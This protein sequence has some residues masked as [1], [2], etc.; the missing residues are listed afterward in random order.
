MSDVRSKEH[1]PWDT[2]LAGSRGKKTAVTVRD[3]S[4][5]LKARDR[6]GIAALIRLRFNER[7]LDPVLDGSKPH[8]FAMLAICCL[9][10]EALESFRHGWKGTQGTK[11]GGE[12]A[13][14]TFLDTHDEFKDL[15]SVASEFYTHVRCGILHQAETT[16]CWMV[17][18]R[19]ELFSTGGALRRISASEFGKRLRIVLNK[20]TDGL[21]TT[22]WR[23][24]SWR[25]V[26]RKFRSICS[27]CGLPSE[28]VKKLQ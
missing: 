20:Y 10:V 5:M 3:Y 1:D 26:R 28:D 17:N 7:Y 9:M 13:F 16:G 18:R 14:R 11:G 12:A 25:N 4:R 8:G 6:T 23:D 19:S 2:I 15:R 27:N 22:D 21:E 24:P